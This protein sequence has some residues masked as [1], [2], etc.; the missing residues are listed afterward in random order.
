METKK[1]TEEELAEAVEKFKKTEEKGSFY[2]I[3]VKLYCNGFEIEA[4]LFLLATWNSSRFQFTKIDIH[5]L[6]KN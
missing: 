1:L 3:A 2:D 6:E 4:Y 5:E